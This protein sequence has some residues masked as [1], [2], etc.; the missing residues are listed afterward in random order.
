M[1]TPPLEVTCK[2]C[3][4]PQHGTRLQSVTEEDVLHKIT[5]LREKRKTTAFLCRRAG[6]LTFHA[7]LHLLQVA[8]GNPH[9]AGVEHEFVFVFRAHVRRRR[10]EKEYARVARGYLVVADVGVAEAADHHLVAAVQENVT[11]DAGLPFQVAPH[12][13]L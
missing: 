13:D 6:P 8:E 1:S 3:D 9:Q 2:N 4:Y 10:V 12:P 7:L 5:H 11:V